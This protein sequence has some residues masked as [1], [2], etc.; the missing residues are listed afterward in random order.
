MRCSVVCS[1]QMKRKGKRI[2][3]ITL[4]MKNNNRIFIIIER[5]PNWIEHTL[6]FQRRGERYEMQ[7]DVG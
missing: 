6:N 3:M 1:L 5:E 7:R 2:T 4:M